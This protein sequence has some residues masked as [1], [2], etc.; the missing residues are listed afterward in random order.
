[1]YNMLLYKYLFLSVFNYPLLTTVLNVPSV[2]NKR[3]VT[4]HYNFLEKNDNK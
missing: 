1:M 4:I 3:A 2:L